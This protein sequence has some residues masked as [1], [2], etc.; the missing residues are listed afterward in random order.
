M[1]R[2]FPFG[3]PGSTALYMVLYVVTL[4]AHA[5]LLS[6]VLAGSAWVAFRAVRKSAATDLVAEL[7][8]DWLP[9][10]LGA[11]IT[12]GVAPLLF[13]QVLYQ[14]SFYTANL[15]LFHRWMAVVPVLVTGFYLLY[16]SK[17]GRLDE[18][19]RL[20]TAASVATLL[21]FLFVAWSFTE[22]HLLS[23]DRERWPEFYAAGR[24]FYTDAPLAPRLL[25]WIAGA[26]PLLAAAIGWQVW[27][28]NPDDATGRTPARQLAIAAIAGLLIAT[29]A[30]LLYARGLDAAAR[31]TLT[32]PFAGPWLA[33]G[34]TG[35]LFQLGAWTQIFRTGRVAAV[36]LALASAGAMVCVLAACVAREAIRLSTLDLSA[37][38]A[39]H[40]RAATASGLPLFLLFL[41][42]NT[43]LI[44]WAIRLVRRGLRSN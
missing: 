6:Y 36:P 38:A 31:A 37:L 39:I 29:G 10:A 5:V 28:R 25:T 18:R 1:E 11:A 27:A 34:A 26:F 24:H 23:L 33:A 42:L 15:L 4:A 13:V 20:R 7:L 8:R 41:A 14:E 44:I 2:A 12:A 32:G 17:S 22:N 30:A 40:Q 19:P 21:C 43:A 35:L 3:L 16:L 9:F